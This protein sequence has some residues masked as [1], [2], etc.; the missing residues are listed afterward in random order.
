M[1]FTV[2]SGEEIKYFS[3]TKIEQSNHL[4]RVK[5]L[6]YLLAISLQCFHE[7]DQRFYFYLF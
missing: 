3:K 6:Q 1:N 5:L 4:E 2:D 7:V